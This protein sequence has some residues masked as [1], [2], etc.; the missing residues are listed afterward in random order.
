MF[1]PSTRKEVKQL[2]WDGLDVILITGDAYL[3]SSFIGVAAIGKALLRADYKV[4]VIAQPDIR[5]EKDIIRLGAPR[6]FWGVTA[7]CV[8]SMVANYTP[9][10]KRRKQDDFTPGGLNN[11]RPDRATIIY[12]NLIRRYC[13]TRVPI[14]LGGI[15]ASLR[16][17]AH[18][19]YWDNQVRRSVLFD[20]KADILVY[21]MGEKAVLDLAKRLDKDTDWKNVRGICYIAKQPRDDY[22]ILPSFREVQEDKAK[23]VEAFHRFYRNND[24]CSGRG[25]CQQQNVRYLI[26]NPPQH[27]LT[28]DEMDRTYSLDYERAIHPYDKRAGDVK[29]VETIRHSITT[30]RGCF[31]ECN[32]CSIAVHQ[33]RKISSRSEGSILKEAEIIAGLP[34][35]KGYIL[36]VGGPTANMYGMECKQTKGHCR[37]KRCLTPRT[38]SKLTAGHRRQV[39]M[40][41]KLR[42]IPGIKKVFVASGIRYDLV[43]EDSQWGLEYLKEIVNHHVSGQM[44]VAPEHSEKSVLALMGKPPV[45][46]TLSAFK[47]KFDQF[48]KKAGKKQFLTY[49]LIA[50]HPGCAEAEMRSL[51]TFVSKELRLRPEQV[52]IFTPTPST[53]S[54]LMYYT[55]MDPFT[56]EKIFVE[57]ENVKK[58]RQ[59]EIITGK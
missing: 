36:D 23:A 18:Y 25:L 13:T 19:D 7:G 47:R 20:A 59:K 2:G 39:D 12:S 53:Y 1:L 58:Q 45:K 51:K 48:S 32:F 55:V 41:R 46:N 6:L 27:P 8:D 21:G 26:H 28:E 44:K 34:D 3:D 57:K 33:G 35:F 56:G 4:G 24:P 22:L 38:C 42:S 54:T 5:S 9:T 10:K 52:Q 11:R 16:R 50:G 43:M 30:H 37:K 31:G 49:Y 17:I 40:L 14:I 15:E 29:A